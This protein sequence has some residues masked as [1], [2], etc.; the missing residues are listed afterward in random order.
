M[1]TP[2]STDN[3]TNEAAETS[4]FVHEHYRATLAL[5]FFANKAMDYLKE[6]ERLPETS[7][8]A[9]RSRYEARFER[10]GRLAH[11]CADIIAKR[12]NHPHVIAQ[13]KA[14]ERASAS[15][16]YATSHATAGYFSG[17]SGSAHTDGTSSVAAH[18]FNINGMPMVGAT[19]IYGNPFGTTMNDPQ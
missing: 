16:S 15:H 14:M 17:N 1:K 3:R 11:V 8:A 19:D 9:T 13:K 7:D 10:L 5:S 2:N 6:V 12:R 18:M 4:M